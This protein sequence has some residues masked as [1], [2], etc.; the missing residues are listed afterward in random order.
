MP[1]QMGTA[2]IQ[3]LGDLRL[4]EFTS[5]QCF[6]IIRQWRVERSHRGLHADR[7]V[8]GVIGAPDVDERDSAILI[9]A[10]RPF[11]PSAAR[12]AI[13]GIY[14]GDLQDAAQVSIRSGSAGD[15]VL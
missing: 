3:D 13:G 6:E 7:I 4:I 8:D 12:I 1:E 14:S 15:L 10:D 11:K 5:H 9:R 2:R